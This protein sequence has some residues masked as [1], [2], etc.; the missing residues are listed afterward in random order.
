MSKIRSSKAIWA[1]AFLFLAVTTGCA[2]KKDL[3]VKIIENNS[4]SEI[5]KTVDLNSGDEFSK[6][7]LSGKI[8]E[9]DGRF[10]LNTDDMYHVVD[11]EGGYYLTN[12]FE[13]IEKETIV[14]ETNETDVTYSI[15][16][17][18]NE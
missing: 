5:V 9:V 10:I 14:L 8:T 18:K 13:L 1:C 12:G 16:V 11:D 17:S 4:G 15:T 3:A 6:L 7:D 2:E